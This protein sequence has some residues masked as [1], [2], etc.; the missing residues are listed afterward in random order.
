MTTTISDHYA[1]FLSLKDNNLPKGNK[2]RKL[3]RDYKEM[4]KN[5]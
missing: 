5:L 1:Q 3:V 2:E 4:I